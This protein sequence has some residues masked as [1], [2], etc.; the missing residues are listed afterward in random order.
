MYCWENWSFFVAFDVTQG[1][2]CDLRNE[3]FW[4][5][6]LLKSWKIVAC[7]PFEDREAKTEQ[8]TEYACETLFD[9]DVCPSEIYQ[10]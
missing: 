7:Y 10:I 2:F 3:F 1:R 9:S 5:I 6:Q 4:E 8:P